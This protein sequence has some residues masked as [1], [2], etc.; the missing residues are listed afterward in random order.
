[1]QARL[2]TRI[3]LIALAGAAYVLGTHWLMTRAHESPWNV[4]GVLTPMLAA[5]AIGAWR[6]GQHWLGAGTTLVIAGLCTLALIGVHVSAQVLYLAQHAGMHSFL[7][8]V[9]GSSL[10]AGQKP[11]IT[12]MAE[13]V[14]RN[15][16]AAMVVYTRK[17]TVAWT[18]YFIGMTLISLA[19]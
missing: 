14:H 6:A 15:F 12:A 13:R 9:F 16:T 2:G 7:A 5:I 11:L 3:V 17:V 8:A 19:L 4:V 1:M 18:L 10:R